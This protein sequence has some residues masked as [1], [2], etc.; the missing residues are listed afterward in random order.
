MPA[1]LVPENSIRGVAEVR[2]EKPEITIGR[3]RQ[4]DVCLEDASVSRV[5]ARIRT[6]TDGYVLEDN[7]SLHGTQ[8]NG[9]PVTLR[10]LDDNDLIDVGIY[11][12]RFVQ[13]EAWQKNPTSAMEQIPHLRL[14]LE[15]TKL[16]NS[17]LDLKDV[18]EHVID[19]VIRVTCAERGFLMTIN[20]KT[21]WNFGS[22]E[23]WTG[24]L[25]KRMTSRSVSVLWSTCA[26]PEFRS[27]SRIR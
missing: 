4:N 2:I 10:R 27:S 19:A 6:T 3:S 11:R 20:P 12:F 21:N 15:V 22:R 1:R 16:I 13:S 8:V 17:S 23:I 5:H 14:L 18:L 9:S 26:R 24:P 7:G 25:S